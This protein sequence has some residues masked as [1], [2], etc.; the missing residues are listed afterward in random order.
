MQTCD[1]QG[2]NTIKFQLLMWSL[3]GIPEGNLRRLMH[4]D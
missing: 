2:N 3:P 1:Q 4:A